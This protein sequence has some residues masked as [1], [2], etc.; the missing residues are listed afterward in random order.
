MS[1][2]IKTIFVDMRRA[3]ISYGF[4]AAV[5]AVC[6]FYYAASWNEIKNAPDILYL[7]KIAAE[8]SGIGTLVIILCVLPYTNSFC[9]DWNSQYIKFITIRSDI[10]NYGIS[11]V[12]SCALSSG[13][14]IA[15]GM[16][17]FFISLMPWIKLVSTSA[18]NFQ[19][20]ATQTLGGIYLMQGHYV[21][22]FAVYVYLAFLAGAF[23]SVIGLCASAYL[24]NKYVALCTPFIAYSVV[25]IITAGFP[26]WLRLNRIAEG[27]F[28]MNGTFLSL[29]YVTLLY[30]ILIICIGLLFV[31]TV[32]RRLSNG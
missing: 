12:I 26:V 13:C 22:Y 24:P 20:F 9:T 6:I 5:F 18:G 25:N 17:L 1:R 16:I 23:W 29:A 21:L 7:Y 30:S 10:R 19:S 32:K 15:A 8:A 28:I 2:I 14:A 27:S 31:N 3:F 4:F 11:K